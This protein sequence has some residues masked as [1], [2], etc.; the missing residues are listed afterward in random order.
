MRGCIE[1]SEGLA[2][3]VQ[4]FESIRSSLMYLGV[5]RAIHRAHVEKLQDHQIE[6]GTNIIHRWMQQ[7]Y[8]VVRGRVLFRASNLPS[9]RIPG[10]HIVIPQGAACDEVC[11]RRIYVSTSLTR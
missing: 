8:G 4:D 1:V 9:N 10:T 2:R 7:N 6:D 3:W 11:V 5:K